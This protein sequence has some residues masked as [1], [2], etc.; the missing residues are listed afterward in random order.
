MYAFSEPHSQVSLRSHTPDVAGTSFLQKQ[1]DDL[2]VHGCASFPYSTLQQQPD[3]TGTG[4]S[5]EHHKHDKKGP[6][7]KL[8]P[9][10]VFIVALIAGAV[11]QA[12]WPVGLSDSLLLRYLGVTLCVLAIVALIAIGLMFHRHKTSI[13]PWE[14]T[15]KV[16]SHG[17]YAYSRNPIYVGFCFIAIGIGLAQNSLWLT[18]SFL[19]AAFIV[20]HT[21]IVREEKYLEKKFGEEYRRYKEKVRRWL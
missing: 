12:V 9:P 20:F 14:P 16:M 1:P 15:N 21:A 5:P 19:P 11:I 6:G 3:A 10:L 7:V 4:D 2:I 8:P 17:P 18:L 13:K